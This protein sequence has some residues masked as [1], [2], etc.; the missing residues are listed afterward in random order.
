MKLLRVL[1]ILA[2]VAVP[3][4]PQTGFPCQPTDITYSDVVRSGCPDIAIDL[5]W[6]INFPSTVISFTDKGKGEC[7]FAVTCNGEASE[8]SAY[9]KFSVQVNWT[10]NQIT[11]LSWV[12]DGKIRELQSQ[13]CARARWLKPIEVVAEFGP[14]RY[15]FVDTRSCG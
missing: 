15:S 1:L 12:N 6:F 9:P 10:N 3:A 11:I 2:L 13:P 5:T 4:S 7:A 14:Q 8:V